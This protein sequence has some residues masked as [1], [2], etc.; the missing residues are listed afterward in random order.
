MSVSLPYHAAM[1]TEPNLITVIDF[2]TA[3]HS[4]ASAC[5]IGVAVI[6]AG[7]I[8]ARVERLIRPPKGFG[9]FRDDFSAIH[10]ITHRDVCGAPGF[11]AVFHDLLPHLSSAVL[12][13][14]NAAFD[15]G[16]LRTLLRHYG[17]SFACDY[18]CT[19]TVA[20]AA[21]PDLP[22]H[23]LKTVAGHLGIDLDHHRAGSDANAA[24]GII[25]AVLAANGT[26]M[27]QLIA[28]HTRRFSSVKN[29]LTNG[30]ICDVG[31]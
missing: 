14:H 20:R 6:E 21:W 12:A 22:A 1:Q 4:R 7:K 5:S 18:F 28:S 17:I 31:H 27:Q 15:M 8:T 24:A 29:T 2:E 23:D 26:K 13:A 9:W 3:N 30:G 10:G 11:D 25:L 19:L 16:V